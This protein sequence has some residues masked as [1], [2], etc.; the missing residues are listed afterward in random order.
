V[1]EQQALFCATNART[2]VP[3]PSKLD[4]AARNALAKKWAVMP[5]ATTAEFDV[6]SACAKKL[7]T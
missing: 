7:A 6:T 4:Y 1:V 3:D 2:E 5:G